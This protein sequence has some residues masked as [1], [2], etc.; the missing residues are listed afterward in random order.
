[1][2]LVLQV[3]LTAEESAKIAARPELLEQ[4]A[5]TTV[6][7]VEAAGQ[8]GGKIVTGEIVDDKGVVLQRVP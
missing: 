5:I 4:I 2:D 1:M 8:V 6:V 7:T 3:R